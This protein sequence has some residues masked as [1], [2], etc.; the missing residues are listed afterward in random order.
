MDTKQE[1]KEQNT[2]RKG[3]WK[4]W[5][6]LVLIILLFPIVLSFLLQFKVFQNWAVDRTTTY[7]SRDFDG[8]ISVGEVDFSMFDGIKVKEFVLVD[9]QDTILYAE[10]MNIGLGSSLITLYNNDLDLSTVT[11]QSPRIKII[12]E[13]GSHETGMALLL[14]KILGTPSDKD[15]DT[16][17]PRVSLDKIILENGSVLL[18]DR[19]NN[20]TQHISI[21]K[22]EVLVNSYDPELLDIKSIRLYEPKIRLEKTDQSFDLSIEEGG[23][24]ADKIENAQK[25]RIAK[26]TIVDG[27]FNYD[28]YTASNH[29][30]TGSFNVNDIEVNDIQVSATKLTWDGDKSV[31]ANIQNLSLKERNGFQIKKLSSPD[32]HVSDV[33]IALPSFRLETGHSTLNRSIS[34]VYDAYDAFNNFNDD[35][36]FQT[37][38]RESKIGVKDLLYFIPDLKKVPYFSDPSEVIDVDG[39]I[40]GSINALE[41]ENLYVRTGDLMLKGDLKTQNLTIKHEEFL[42]IR[43]DTLIS[44]IATIEKIVPRFKPIKN[45]YR[46]GQINYSGSFKGLINDFE[47]RGSIR[48][49]LGESTLDLHFDTSE[50]VATYKGYIAVENFNL[51]EWSGNDKLGYTSF[52]G[53]I[54]EGRGVKISDIQADVNAQISYFDF[55]GYRHKNF[56]L[57]GR[58]DNSSFRGE[59]DISNNDAELSIDGLIDFNNK[60]PTYNF[61]SQIAK[62]QLDSLGFSNRFKEVKGSLTLN[63]SGSTIDSLVGS[64]HAKNISVSEQGEV[65]SLE[66]V[67]LEA[68]NDEKNRS[69]QLNSD[70]GEMGI[71]GDFSFRKMIPIIRRSLQKNYAAYWKGSPDSIRFTGDQVF[72]FYADIKDTKNLMSILTNDKSRAYNVSLQGDVHTGKD[73]YDIN[74]SMD[75]LVGVAS[76]EKAMVNITSRKGE[77]TIDLTLDSLQVGGVDIPNA[78]LS[79]LVEDGKYRLQ[80][81]STSILNDSNYVDVSLSGRRED[82]GFSIHFDQDSIRFLDSLWTFSPENQV[83]IRDGSFDID[84]FYITDGNRRVVIN[85]LSN[86]GLELALRKFDFSTIDRRYIKDKYIRLSGEGDVEVFVNDIY[87]DSPILIGRA[88]MPSFYINKDDFGHITLNFS[89][90]KSDILDVNLN[91]SKGD[92]SLV[93]IGEYNVKSQRVEAS[94]K[95]SLIPMRLFEH[96]LVSG[97]HDT[98]GGLDVQG[99]ISGPIDDLKMS[100]TGLIHKAGTT[101]DYTGVSYNFD[102]ETFTFDEKFIDLTGGRIYDEDGDYGVVTGGLYH[103][104]FYRFGLRANITGDNV[105]ALNTTKEDNPVYYGRGKGYVSADFNGPFNA[106]NMRINCETKKGSIIHIPIESTTSNVDNN[107][108]TFIKKEDLLGEKKEQEEKVKLNPLDIEIELSMTPEATVHLIFDENYGDVIKGKGRGNMKMYFTRLGDFN[109]YGDY[110]I[111][112]GEYL[113]TALGFIAK[114][115]DVRKGSRIVW[116]GDPIDA[117]LDVIADYR[118]RS[119]LNVFLSEYLTDLNSDE[120]KNKTEIDLQLLLGNTLYSPSVNFDLSFPNVTGDLRSLVESKL[121]T[122]KSNQNELNNQVMGL[123]VFNSFLASNTFGGVA[124]QN[125]QAAGIS[126]ISEFVSSQ[127]SLL[128]TGLLNEALSENGLISGI[129]FDIGLHKNSFLGINTNNSFLP[130]E[131]EVHLK[132]KFR[133]WDER[134]SLNV[135]GNYVRAPII[136]IQEYVTGDFILEYFLTNDRKLKLRMYGKYDYDEAATDRRLRYGLG[137]GYRTEFGSMIALRDRLVKDIKES[138]QRNKSGT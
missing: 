18:A 121:Y 15:K 55:N 136:N 112:E 127:L 24:V 21:S 52:K 47:T 133:F 28:N 2:K 20:T 108:I 82:D 60:V 61:T 32:V 88:D 77:G 3:R 113:F 31:Y 86:K 118:V 66:N 16:K 105:L 49:D 35:V 123:I 39:Y 103:D 22:A 71:Q 122:L 138:V 107:F 97:I 65:Y 131:I 75:S 23:T 81:K 58:F 99:T 85:D 46:L 87:A 17:N 14:R 5:L 111:E 26:I 132:N 110:N 102:Q 13:K 12:K 130:D 119:P 137:I 50:D 115:F 34:L 73:I 48:T 129:D 135:G 57:D 125:Y 67:V 79:G 64:L 83:L 6:L 134:L 124:G 27:A 8:E 116:T 59:A 120:S 53:E 36:V 114:S 54:K 95:S 69:I 72:S 1:G 104:M 92:T 4:R 9:R 42:D 96:I 51:R 74:G 63:A 68:K 10:S 33:N 7:L 44:D 94:A 78:K 128:F 89:K 90:G 84:D 29:G 126:T 80:L 25:I 70:I 93:L 106:V 101:V 117:S 41:A 38:L 76:L 56:N 30:R 98:Y 37:H 45:L 40:H 100:G 43:I 109:I 19:N 11:L 91:L 62:L